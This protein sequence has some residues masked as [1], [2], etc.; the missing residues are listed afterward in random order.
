MVVVALHPLAPLPSHSPKSSA[1]ESISLSH[2]VAIED[3][4]THPLSPSVC[5]HL[6]LSTTHKKC[7]ATSPNPFATVLA[8]C[9]NSLPYNDDDVDKL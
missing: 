3:T 9:S 7:S 5:S 8:L 1:L 2:L 4:S 6:K